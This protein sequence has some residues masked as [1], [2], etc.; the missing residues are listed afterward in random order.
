MFDIDSLPDMYE[1]M[2]DRPALIYDSLSNLTHLLTKNLTMICS[3]FTNQLNYT[4]QQCET[5][6][7]NTVI[8]LNQVRKKHKIE[9]DN[10]NIF[11]AKE[12]KRFNSR[13]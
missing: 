12:K 3:F 7:N 10:M 11:S 9:N 5:F 6:F 4:Y 1:T 2:I 8:N 13:S